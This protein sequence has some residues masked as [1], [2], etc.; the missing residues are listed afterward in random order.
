[1][2]RDRHAGTDAV[3]VVEACQVWLLLVQL[4]DH[5]AARFDEC[6]EGVEG[7]GRDEASLLV[8]RSRLDDGDVQRFPGREGALP[9][10]V[11][12]L[13]NPTVEELP[14]PLVDRRPR[15]LAQVREPASN[16]ESS[17]ARFESSCRRAPGEE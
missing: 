16:A 8:N 17:S 11:R 13:A 14:G 2:N 1:T 4:H 12:V 15:G 5:A 9:H 3:D 7:E 10:E 6:R